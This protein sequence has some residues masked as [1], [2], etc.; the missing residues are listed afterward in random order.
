M[1]L[2]LNSQYINFNHKVPKDLTTVYSHY[3]FWIYVNYSVFSVTI[4]MYSNYSVCT[5]KTVYV[6]LKMYLQGLLIE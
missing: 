3:L 5:V 6:L 2:S 1:G 4:F